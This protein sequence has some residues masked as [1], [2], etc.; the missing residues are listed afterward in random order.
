VIIKLAPASS[1]R[2]ARR[3]AEIDNLVVRGDAR[4]SG[5]ARALVTA[6][7][8]WTRSRNVGR[9]EVAVWSFN[10]GA[11]DFYREIGFAPATERLGMDLPTIRS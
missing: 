1:V 9:I 8:E 3:F 11:V 10:S 7:I 2:D 6:S 5:V 4:R